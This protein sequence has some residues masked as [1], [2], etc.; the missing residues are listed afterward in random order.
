MKTLADEILDVLRHPTGDAL[1]DIAARVRESLPRVRDAAFALDKDGRAI[2]IRRGKGG[3]LFLAGKDYPHPV[4]RVC[5]LEFVRKPKSIRVTCSRKCHA[6]YGWRDPESAAK[7]RASIIKA[8]NTPE[9]R[10]KCTDV[11]NRRWAD[12]KQREKLS[13][14]NR[15]RWADPE[16]RARYGSIQR[17]RNQTP[18]SRK[19]ASEARK[20]A[21]ANP[22]T[23]AKMLKGMRE[24]RASQAHIEKLREAAIDRNKDPAFRAAVAER[25]RT[26]MQDPAMREVMR[27]RMKDRWNDPAMRELMLAGCRKGAEERQAT[28]IRAKISA[29]TSEGL[30]KKWRDDPKWRERQTAAL[31]KGRRVRAQ[32]R[33]A[34]KQEQT[35][36][37]A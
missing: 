33:A 13:E 6:A 15:Q 22:E 10:A 25:N 28:E 17:V 36:A 23:R 1:R 8:R 34:Q 29:A 11:N 35:G 14:Q 31:A 5:H 37:P 19:Q 2:L 32:R 4:C 9:S 30:R 24:S 7:R 20:K 12:P 21:W 27:Q 18:E 16:M 3:A 26:R